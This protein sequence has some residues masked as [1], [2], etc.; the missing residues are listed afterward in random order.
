MVTDRGDTPMLTQN[1]TV[2]SIICMVGETKYHHQLQIK[3]VRASK[4]KGIKNESF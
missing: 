1:K 3:L 2:Q 4:L